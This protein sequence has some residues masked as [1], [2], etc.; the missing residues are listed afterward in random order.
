VLNTES[1]KGAYAHAKFNLTAGE[2]IYMLIGQRGEEACSAV[3]T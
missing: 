2:K 1:S 3:R